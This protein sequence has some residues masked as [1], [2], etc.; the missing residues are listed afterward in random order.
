MFKTRKELEIFTES[1]PTFQKPKLKLEQYPTNASIVATAVWD[2]YMR[3]LLDIVLDLGCGT[4]RFAI[5]AAAMGARNVLCV[6]IDP[7]ALDVAKR[8]A[9][10]L[11][12]ETIDF[13]VVDT[14]RLTLTRKFTVGFQNPPFGIWSTRGLDIV[15]LKTALRYVDVVYTIHKLT[16]LDY[17][18]RVV[19]KWGYKFEVLE[20]SYLTLRPVFRHHKKRI[21]KVEIFLARI[22]RLK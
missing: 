21:H 7:E 18:R 22:S 5:A 14:T 16:T 15:F 17:V 8:Y 11:G 3:G 12:F 4:G 10:K 20:K 2:A 1:I 19:E 9:K 6:D 13:L